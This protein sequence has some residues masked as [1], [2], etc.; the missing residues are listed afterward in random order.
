MR[1]YIAANW[2]EL[3][4]FIGV[5]GG[6]GLLGKIVVDKQQNK[7][8]KS[9]EKRVGTV[10][11]DLKLNTAIDEQF[12][13]TIKGDLTDIKGQNKMILKHLLDNK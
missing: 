9:L 3:L 10:E 1:E 12:R 5:G 6:S 4:T 2:Q 8:I 11:T 13:D 7:K